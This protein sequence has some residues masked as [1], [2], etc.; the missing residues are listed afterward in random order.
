MYLL[1]EGLLSLPSPTISPKVQVG[2][3]TWILPAPSKAISFYGC[4]DLSSQGQGAEDY[5]H[6][7]SGVLPDDQCPSFG[8]KWGGP[9]CLQHSQGTGSAVSGSF[10]QVPQGFIQSLCPP[11]QGLGVCLQGSL[12]NTVM[13]FDETCSHWIIWQVESPFD[14]IFFCPALYHGTSKM[15][16]MV[17]LDDLRCPGGRHQFGECLDGICLV[18]F[19]HWIGLQ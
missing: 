2:H 11:L 4:Q 7:Q 1:L 18:C 19:W 16:S 13:T 9:R 5:F 15:S 14:V 10:I 3:T 12:K 6:Y 17:A 8:S